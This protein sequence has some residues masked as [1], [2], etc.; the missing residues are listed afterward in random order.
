[1]PLPIRSNITLGSAVVTLACLCSCGTAPRFADRLEAATACLDSA[2]NDAALSH[3]EVAFTVAACN[4]DRA[5]VMALEVEAQLARGDVEHAGYALDRLK[6]I[7]PAAFITWKTQSVLELRRSGTE[8][9]RAALQAAVGR[10]K[11]PG[12]TVWTRDFGKLLDALDAFRDGDLVAARRHLDG[13]THADVAPSARW[14]L[15][16]LDAIDQVQQRR[17]S[18]SARAGAREGI[19]DLIEVARDDARLRDRVMQLARQ[20][21]LDQDLDDM[22]PA[23]LRE[24]SRRCPSPLVVASLAA[25]ARLAVEQTPSR[26]RSM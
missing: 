12:Q 2:Q 13:I 4:D 22:Q 14:L 10:A 5:Q 16:R 6:L 11:A 15:G 23:D 7:A 17:V 3:L 21:G 20:I 18:A 19:A 25:V 26:N 8:P 9:A 24:R 1:M